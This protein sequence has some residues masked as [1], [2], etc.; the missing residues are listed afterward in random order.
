VSSEK[1]L[2]VRA[3]ESEAGGF[4]EAVLPAPSGK[5]LRR[6]FLRLVSLSLP[7]EEAVLAL[8]AT[9]PSS[10][11]EISSARACEK[12]KVVTRC[13]SL[14]KGMLQQGFLL[15]RSFGVVLERH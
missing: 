10:T 8:G 1:G 13:P 9:E 7:E 4:D 11:G 15:R 5:E 12:G 6:R 2:M 14:K 3:I